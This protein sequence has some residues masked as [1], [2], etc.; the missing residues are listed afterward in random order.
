ML[1]KLKELRTSNEEGF[2]LIE[3]MIVVVII[4]ILAAIAIPIFANQQKSAIQA[5]VKSDV[6]SL[7]IQVVTYLTKNPQADDLGYLRIGEA[8]PSGPLAVKNAINFTPSDKSTTVR[9]RNN[10]DNLGIGSWDDWYVV[11]ANTAAAE[12]SGGQYRYVWSNKTGKFT[13][14]NS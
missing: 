6:K 1:K 14:T 3:L 2:T 11:G 7:Q 8:A 12:T 13:E 4:G 9:V 10:A 5:G